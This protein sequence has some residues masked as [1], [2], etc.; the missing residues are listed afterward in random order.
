MSDIASLWVEG[1]GDVRVARIAGEVDSSNVTE[2]GHELLSSVPN[3]SRALV[4][5]LTETSYMDS[6]GISLIFDVASRLR[7]RRQELR[8]VVPPRSFIAEV[9]RTVS[10]DGVANVD[11]A[12]SE[13]LRA[14]RPNAPDEE[15]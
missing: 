10:L 5:D 12:L 9:L 4:L 6:S 14:V 3:D 13:A 2:L 11:G 8:L 7:N 15:N 1:S